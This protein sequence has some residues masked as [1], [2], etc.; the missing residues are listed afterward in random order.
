MNN[1]SFN[2]LTLMIWI[3][4]SI[5]SQVPQFYLL[6]ALFCN[7]ILWFRVF[8]LK[9]PPNLCTPF[10]TVGEGKD[11]TDEMVAPWKETTLQIISSN[12]EANDIYNADE[13]G[14]FYQAFPPDYYYY[15]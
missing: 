12:Y 8:N 13:F 6:L 3:R 10:F 5:F 14:R 2:S 9:S 7:S 1:S 11:V 15:Y 4:K